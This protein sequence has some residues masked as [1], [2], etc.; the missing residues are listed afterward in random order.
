MSAGAQHSDSIYSMFVHIPGLKVVAPSTPADAKGLLISSIRDPDPVIFVENRMLYNTK[1]HVPEEAYSIPLGKAD[2]KR[3]GD[4]CTIVAISRM[5][6]VALEA[7]T[8]LET[9]GWSVEVIDPR[10]QGGL[11]KPVGELALH[12]VEGPWNRNN[13][14]PFCLWPDLLD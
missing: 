11:G 1:G 2:V 13:E 6:H 3:E 5:V 8:E 14:C 9:K 10:S 12:V 7:A 4:D